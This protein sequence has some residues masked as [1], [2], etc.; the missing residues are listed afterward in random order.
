MSPVSNRDDDF[1]LPIPKQY[2]L[3]KPGVYVGVTAAV[4]KGNYNGARAYLAV[5][6]DVFESAEALGSGEEA[7]ATGVPGF[8]NLESGPASRYARFLRLLFPE[9]QPRS[10]RATD[11]VGK[12]LEVEVVTVECNPNGKTLPES[13][14]YS[15]VSEVVGRVA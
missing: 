12:A 3:V 5:S 7:I 10:L 2:P 8:F 14:H 13:S 9:G 6:F 4:R 1:A 15:K 11:L